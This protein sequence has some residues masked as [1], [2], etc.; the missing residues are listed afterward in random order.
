MKRVTWMASLIVG[1]IWLAA[2]ASAS[3]TWTKPGV[4]EEQRGRDTLDCLT[5]ARRVTTGPAGPVEQV[6]QDRYRRCMMDRGYTFMRGRWIASRR[7]PSNIDCPPSRRCLASPNPVGSSGMAP[8]YS[9]CSDVARHSRRQDPEGRQARR[10]SGRAADQGGAGRQSEAAK[11]LGV[12][13]PQAIMVRADR[14]IE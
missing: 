1:H 12:T 2:S 4:T 7:S 8:M 11:T 13:I 5:E 6:N 9:R 14:V 3:D 10:P